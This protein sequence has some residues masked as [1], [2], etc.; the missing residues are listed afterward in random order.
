MGAS[1]QLKLWPVCVCV[2]VCDAGALELERRPAKTHGG[3]GRLCFITSPLTLELSSTVLAQDHFY[4]DFCGLP[5]IFQ[6]QAEPMLMIDQLHCLEGT[7]FSF[8]LM[9]S[10]C[11]G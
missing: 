6:T 2:S 9:S 5:S 1:A 7:L 8:G 11:A 4:S 3:H 10:K